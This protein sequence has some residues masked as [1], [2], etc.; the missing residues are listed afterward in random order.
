MSLENDLQILESLSIDEIYHR[1][2]TQLLAQTLGADEFSD[3]EIIE[4]AMTWSAQMES[5]LRT[6][7]CG[8][9]VYTL[10][11]Q[12]PTRWEW[13]MIVAAIADLVA[14]LALP[15]SPASVSALLL[16]KGLDNLCRQDQPIQAE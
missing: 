1:I 7:I 15:V 5:K 12:S 2:G 14:T 10:Y 3:E 8:S 11:V 13:V 16:K 4:E 9:R 6:I